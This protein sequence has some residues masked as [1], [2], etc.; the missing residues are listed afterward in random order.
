VDKLPEL[1][2]PAGSLEKLKVAVDYGADAVYLAGQNFGLRA[3]ADNFTETELR[4]GI[5]Y[6]HQNDVKVYVVLNGFLHDDDLQGLPSFVDLLEELAVDAVIVSDLGVIET[7]KKHSR[8]E[9]HLSTQ[10]SCLNSYSGFD[11][12]GTTD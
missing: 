1:L 4:A 3:A 9:I 12:G 11:C 7:V 10:A 6:A 8:L 2:I 5:Q